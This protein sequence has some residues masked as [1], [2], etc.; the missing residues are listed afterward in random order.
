[1]YNYV[2]QYNNIFLNIVLKHFFND[3]IQFDL[4]AVVIDFVTYLA[5]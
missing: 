4:M 5:L 2:V 3:T 1:M